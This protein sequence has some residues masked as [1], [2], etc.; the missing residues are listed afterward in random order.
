MRKLISIL[1]VILI[2]TCF[3]TPILVSSHSGRTDENGGH[4]DNINGGYHYHHGYPAHQ[5]NNGT[6]PYNYKD[7][8]EHDYQTG[9]NKFGEILL[10]IIKIILLTLNILVFGLLGWFFV[11]INLLLFLLWFCEKILKVVANES[12]VS[13]IT[14]VIIIVISTIIASIIVLNS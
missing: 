2:L 7:T 11:Y 5:H 1:S 3:I 13:K 8:T 10:T 12:A 14:I 6:C 9:V 4:Y